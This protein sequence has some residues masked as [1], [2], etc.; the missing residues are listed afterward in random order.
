[1]SRKISPAAKAAFQRAGFLTE[2]EEFRLA[3]LANAGD[4]RAMTRLIKAYEPLTRG[5]A[6]RHKSQTPLEDRIQI[7]NT[8]LW[9]AITKF[10]P[11]R[12][13]RLSAYAKFWIRRDLDDAGAKAAS[14]LFLGNSKQRRAA[15]QNVLKVC[16][17]LGIDPTMPLTEPQVAAVAEQIGIQPHDVRG[18]VETGDA[19]FSVSV[20]TL[21]DDGDIEQA[22]IIQDENDKRLELLQD[23]ISQLDELDAE[24]IRLTV[25]SEKPQSITPLLKQHGIKMTAAE[26]SVAAKSKLGDIVTS[27]AQRRGMM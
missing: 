18:V 25:L 14:R 9:H 26:A 11:E 16:G 15:H 27:A 10:E 3:R 22:I 1:M 21:V 19:A 12:G 5:M 13:R 4:E 8:A 20:D 2:D 7:A 6:I 24:I 23:A 17:Q